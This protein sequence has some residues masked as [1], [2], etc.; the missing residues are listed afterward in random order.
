MKHTTA[1]ND[2][3]VALTDAR[4][5]GQALSDFPGELPASLQDAYEIQSL[6]LERWQDTVAGWKVGGIPP[7]FRAGDPTDRLAGPIFASSIGTIADGESITV[8]IYDGGS[9]AIEAEY[10]LRLAQGVAPGTRKYSD[11]EL[12]ALVDKIYVGAEIASSPVPGINDIGPLAVISD[13]GNNGGLQVGPEIDEQARSALSSISVRVTIDGEVAGEAVADERPSG[14]FAALE[15]LLQNCGERGI[16][17]PKGTLVSS[18]AITGVHDV[19]TASKSTVTF[20][21]IASFDIQYQASSA[22]Q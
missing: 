20:E 19:T 16:V 5:S 18:G 10:V 2:V 13:F 9:A 3:S 21:G 11:E 4:R 7:V 14:P 12:F 22:G 1:F 15:F 8:P 6:S 17:L